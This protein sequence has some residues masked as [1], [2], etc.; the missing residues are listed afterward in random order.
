MPYTVDYSTSSKTAIVVNDGTVDTTTSLSLIG[1]NYTNFGELLNE[2]L[3][4]LLEKKS[5][6]LISNFDKSTATPIHESIGTFDLILQ[7]LIVAEFSSG[8]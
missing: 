2:N 7:N 4:K 1:K 8:K 5:K 3:I 6:F